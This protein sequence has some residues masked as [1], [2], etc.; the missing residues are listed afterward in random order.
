MPAVSVD[1]YRFVEVELVVEALVEKKFDDVAFTNDA[2]P[3]TL[4]VVAEI[5][6]PSK[7]ELVMVESEIATLCNSLILLVWAIT[8]Y[9]CADC[10][11]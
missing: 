11:L 6:E 1:E 7:L 4:N 9:T 8:W 5:A 2:P 10:V 3:E